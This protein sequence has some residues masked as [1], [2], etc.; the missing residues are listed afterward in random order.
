MP[1]RRTLYSV[2]NEL[3]KKSKEAA[4]LAIQTFNN[5]NI[6]FKS[7][8]FI[9]LI[10]IAWTYLL[11]AFYR[12]QGTDYRYYEMNGQRK[13]YDRTANGAYK[14]WELKRCL[15]N[16]G[17]PID[18]I[19][20]K[21]LKF[22]IGIR[23]EIEHQMTRKI[24]DALTAKFQACVLNYNHYLK[25]LFFDSGLE[26]FI[27]FS[28][29]LSA[30]SEEQRQ[31]LQD[32]D[33]PE[34]VE[35][36]IKNYDESLEEGIYNS[37]QYAFRM[38]FTPKLVNNVKQADKVVEFIKAD[39]PMAAEINRTY[40]LIRDT[41]KSKYTPTQIVQTMHE[42][43]YP[44]FNIRNHT[45]LWQQNDAKNPEKH[46]GILVAG[47]VWFWYEGWVKIVREYCKQN[48]VLFR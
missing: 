42:E 37:P 9:V 44:R 36:F 17:S 35:T 31:M 3:I 19:S 28:I 23:H 32:L 14:Y 13:K 15:D 47:K 29:Q 40:A 5:P 21:N 41:E 16:E 45:E 2:K 1:R 12:E 24:D 33:L 46:L 30:I 43:G 7:E 4:L 34:N 39:S 10:I 18:N 8:S 25:S 22:L 38:I 48:I 11:H 20:S 27:T 26:E 6:Q